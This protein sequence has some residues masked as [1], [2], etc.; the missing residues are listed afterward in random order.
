[1]SV[2]YFFIFNETT[3]EVLRSVS[4]DPNI[5]GLQT[6]PG[7]SIIIA[8]PNTQGNEYYIDLD[9]LTQVPFPER[10]SELHQFQE[11]RAQKRMR[12][13]L[14]RLSPKKALFASPL[15]LTQIR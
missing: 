10:P 9:T 12:R 13:S 14:M 2:P 5:A 8:S 4:C 15:T 6:L 1:M 11:F 7:E 3:G